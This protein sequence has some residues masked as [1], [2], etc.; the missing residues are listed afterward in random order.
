M[1][2]HRTV[3][4]IDETQLSLLVAGAAVCVMTPFTDVE[5]RLSPTKPYG[6][7]KGRAADRLSA[8]RPEMHRGKEQRIGSNQHQDD[9]QR[10]PG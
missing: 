2:K 3:I 1:V 6:G 8:R 9:F 5:I 7:T 10:Q 4:V